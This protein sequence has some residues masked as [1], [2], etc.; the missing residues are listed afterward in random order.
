MK[1]AKFS[2]DI[3]RDGAVL[4]A[5]VSGTILTTQQGGVEETDGNFTLPPGQSIAPRDDCELQLD[6]GRIAPITILFGQMSIPGLPTM[7]N[8]WLNGAWR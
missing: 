2:G 7:V 4:F 6:D 5:G 3:L 1:P 8:F